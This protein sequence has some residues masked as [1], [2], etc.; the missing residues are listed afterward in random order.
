MKITN[1]YNDSN[2]TPNDAKRDVFVQW[3]RRLFFCKHVTNF[4]KTERAS[5]GIFDTEG[6]GLNAFLNLLSPNDSDSYESRSSAII[7]LPVI[8]L[9]QFHK[10]INWPF[11]RVCQRQCHWYIASPLTIL[12]YLH[13]GSYRVLNSW[14]SLEIC[15]AIFQT[16]KKS[17]K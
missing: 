15:P 1:N 8:T 11:K 13:M 5:V 14:K 2:N 4:G 16:W 17:G 6:K 10:I 12:L 7:F 9:L 3:G